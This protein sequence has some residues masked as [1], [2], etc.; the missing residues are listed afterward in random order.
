MQ[1]I[2]SKAVSFSIQNSFANGKITGTLQ[3][4]TNQPASG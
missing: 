1:K 4:D 2:V 3:L